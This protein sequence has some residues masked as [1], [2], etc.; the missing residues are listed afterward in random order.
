M[1]HMVLKDLIKQSMIATIYVIL[2][3]TL[4]FASFGVVQFRVA[5]VLMVLVLLDKK[6][7]IGV[8][9]GCFVANLLG[10]AIIIDV[11]FGTMATAI[12]GM[13]MYM[14]RKKIGIALLWPAL[15]NGIIVGIIL[16]YGYLLAPIYIS[17][18]SVFFG[19]FVV[20]Y[21]LGLPVYLAIKDSKSLSEFLKG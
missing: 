18:P 2:V 12:A 19:E 21:A 17:I 1:K 6:S 14:T 7:I 5:E 20:L 11:I 8:T 15:I 13:L 10:G 3:Y 4:S 9:L 16:S